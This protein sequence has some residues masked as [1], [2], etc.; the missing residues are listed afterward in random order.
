HLLPD[1]PPAEVAGRAMV[2]KKLEMFPIECVVRGYLFGG[3]WKEYER[4]QSVCG[5]RL[6]AGL[7]EGDRLPEPIFTP[8]YKAPLGEHD[9]NISFDRTIELVGRDAAEKLRELSLGI[10]A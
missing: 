9:E 3:G 8:A 2:A 10:F 4:E 7:R 5:V 1:A 6:P